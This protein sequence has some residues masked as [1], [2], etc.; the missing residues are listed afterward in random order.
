MR[1]QAQHHFSGSVG[2]VIGVLGDP[3]FHRALPLPDLAPPEVLAAEDDG[4]TVRLDL[5]YA[6]TGSIDPMAKRFLGGGDLTWRQEL[7]LDRTSGSGSLHFAADADPKKLHGKA[8]FRFEAAADGGTRRSLQGE[9][10]V[11]IPL[12]GGMAERAIVPGVLE[13]L[14]LEA[15]ALNERLTA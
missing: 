1:F 10:V 2:A 8:S 9:L 3:E 13:R 15:A 5:R 12:V 6:Y 14:D 4:D 7:R 11:S